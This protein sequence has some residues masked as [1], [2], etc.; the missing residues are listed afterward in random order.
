M[1]AMMS[2]RED[3]AP[4]APLSLDDAIAAFV[5][6]RMGGAGTAASDA[7][8]DGQVWG[9][10]GSLMGL[11]KAERQQRR[12]EILA[13]FAPAWI[14]AG[15]RLRAIDP[16]KVRV[17][18]RKTKLKQIKTKRAAVAKI[19]AAN[20]RTPIAPAPAKPSP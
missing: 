9:T 13:A 7:P 1:H 6:A 2:G 19:A 12:H 16:K 8:E 17:Q 5:A 3:A 20:Q 11:A 14:A 10:V 4:A 15:G 18:K